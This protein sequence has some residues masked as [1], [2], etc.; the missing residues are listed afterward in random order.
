MKKQ[1][2]VAIIGFSYRLPGTAPRQFW[3]NLLA[4]RDLVTQVPQ[5]RWGQE[6]YFHPQKT[7]P[8]T[9]YTFAAGSIGDISGFDAEFFGISP[10]EAA[11]MDPQ[12]RLLLELSWE[13]LENSGIRAAEMRGSRC[14]VYIGISSVDY[15][16]RFAEDLA[17]AEPASATGTANSIAANRISYALDLHGPSMSIDTACSSS[18]IAFHLACQS[19]AAGES[20]QAITGGVSLHMHPYGFVTFSKASML[21][22]KGRCNVFDAAGDGYVRS[23]GAGIFVL[24]DHDQAVADGNRI[25][26]IVAG[27]ATNS[28][29]RKSGLTVPSIDAQA[30][31]LT[32]AYAEAGIAPSD[33]DYVEAH[34]TGTAVGDPVETHALGIALGQHR[35]RGNPLLIGS[36]K[37]NIGHLEAASGSAGLVKALYC[38]EHRAVPATI[39]LRDPNPSIR[40]DEWNLRVPT[41]TTPLREKGRLVLGINSFGF[42]GANAHVILESPPPQRQPAAPAGLLL[43]VL[44][45][46]KDADA[47][48][49]AAS[50]WAAFLR[51]PEN[52]S[53]LYEIAYSAAF[54]RDWHDHRAICLAHDKPSLAAALDTIASDAAAT[55]PLETGTLI[56]QPAMVAFVYSG[57][58]SQWDGMGRELLEKSPVFREAVKDVDACFRP[59]AGYSLIDELSGKNG[60]SRYVRTEI[61]QPA[62]FALQVGITSMLRNQGLEAAAVAGHSVGEVAAAWASGA[63][64]LEQATQVIYYRSQAQARTRGQGQMTAVGLG[65]A[66]IMEL[67]AD[68]D[69][70]KLI[71]IAGI[72]NAHSVTVAGAACSLDAMETALRER[73]VFHR[74]LELD[75]AFHSPAMDPI[76]PDIMTALCNL[77]PAATAIPFHSSV[78]GK[79]LDGTALDADY[80]W[81][82]IR[83]PVQFGK[84]IASL[85]EQ[86]TNIFIEIGPHAVLQG[87]VGQVLRDSSTQGCVIKTQMRDDGSVDRIWRSLCQAAIGGAS[88]DWQTWFPVRSR[89][90]QL[91]NYPWQREHYWHGTSP[92]SPRRLSRSRLHPLLGY[93]MND[94]DWVWEN[95]LDTQTCPSLADHVVGDTVVMPGTGYIEMA[96]AA[97]NAWRPETYIEIERLDIHAPLVFNPNQSKRLRLSIDVSDGSF[98]IRSR[99]ADSSDE[100]VRHA[101]GRLASE[102]SALRLRQTL[103]ALATRPPDFDSAH[104]DTLTRAAGLAY[105]PGYCAIEGIWLEGSAAYA[106]FRNPDAIAAELKK[107]HIHPALL[108]CTFQ[109]IIELLQDDPWLQHGTVYVPTCIEELI[110][111]SGAG[112]P[113][114]AQAVLLQRSPL[115][116]TASFTLFDASGN[117]IVWIREARFTSIRTNKCPRERLQLLDYRYS[118]FPHP[119]APPHVPRQL[120][121]RVLKKLSAAVRGDKTTPVVDRYAAEVEPLLDVLCSRFAIRA[122]QSL[123]QGSG[124]LTAARL[125]A[126][127][128]ATPSI[129]PLLNHLLV[130]LRDD[131]VIAAEG[132]DWRFLDSDDLPAAEDIWNGLIRDYPDYLPVIHSVGRVGMHLGDLLHGRRTPEQV[133]LRN[134]SLGNLNF[135]LLLDAGLARVQQH[136]AGAVAMTMKEIP[137]GARLRILEVCKDKPLF[138]A[139]IC[140]KIDFDRCG[141][142]VTTVSPIMVEDCQRLKENFPKINLLNNP[143][144]DPDHPVFPVNELYQLVIIDADLETERDALFALSYAKRL[145]AP[146]GVLVMIEQHP[147]RWMDMVFGT[148]PGWWSETPAG[149]WKSRHRTTGFWR[150]QASKAG[151]LASTTLDMT[152]EIGNGNYIL[153]AHAPESPARVEKT[154]ADVQR[155]WLLLAD[156]DPGEYSAKLANQLTQLLQARQDRVILATPAGQFGSTGNQHYQLDFSDP[157]Q[158]E[159]LLVHA[160]SQSGVIDGV[161]HLYGMADTDN[162]VPPLL[163][164][165]KQIDR[166]ASAALLI[167]ACEATGLHPT[168]WLLTSGVTGNRHHPMQ[169]HASTTKPSGM[170]AA[171]WGFGRTAMNETSAPAIRLV[172]I[173]AAAPLDNIAFTLAREFTDPDDE[174]EIAYTSDGERLAL[175]LRFTPSP[176]PSN[177][178]NE[179]SGPALTRLG[180]STQGQLRNLRWESLPA[181]P[182]ADDELEIEIRA[183]GLNFRDVMY[184]LGLLSEDAVEGG[185][186]GPTL[187]LEFAGVVVSTGP[188]VRGFPPGSRVLGF[189]ANSFSNRLRAKTSNIAL[190]PD[191]MSFEA[192]ATI[193]STFFTVHY[194]LNHLARLGQGEK[195][196][197][198]GAAGGIGIAAVQMARSCG[199]EIFATAGSPEKRDFLRLMG[200]KHVL[201]S[202]SLTYAEEI[203]AINGG[204]GVDVVLNSL[205]GEAINRNLRVLK[206]FGRFIELGKRDFQE[207][208]RIGLRQ[209]RNNISYFAVDADQLM[210][211]RPELTERLFRELMGMFAEGVL[212]PLPYQCFEA[213]EVID[214]FR[215]MQQSRHIGK[216]VVTYDNPIP[217][218][219]NRDPI[220]QKLSLPRDATYLITGGLGGFGLKT[221]E[222]LVE[223]GAGNLV[224]I[225]RSGKPAP[226]A[227]PVL[228][229]MRRNGVRVHTAACDVTDMA[230]LSKLFADTGVTLPPVRGIIHAAAVIEDGVIRNL[231]AGRIRRVLAPKILGAHYLHELTKN[232]NLDFFVMYS[233]A[234]TLFGNPG[235]AAYV[236]ANSYLEAYA[237]SLRAKGHRALCVRWGAIE[238]AGFLARNHDVL[239]ALNKRMGGAPLTSAVALD[240]LEDLLIAD[241]S[242]VG[243]LELDWNAL[244]RF[245]PAASS[246]KFGEIAAGSMENATNDNKQGHQDIHS[247][248]ATLPP[249][250]QVATLTAMLKRE[251]AEILRI[252]PDK[253]DDHRLLHDMGFDS[254]MG[255]ELA[256]AVESRF[257]VRL[258]VMALNDAPTAAKI[259]AII[260]DKLTSMGHGAESVS[261]SE[262]D[263]TEQGQQ[264]AALHGDRKYAEALARTADEMQKSKATLPKI[265]H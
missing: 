45:S 134:S 208:T 103:P 34:G 130:M 224:L 260:L 30:A 21:S 32:H 151:L 100:W 176:A 106:K 201:D 67:L 170:D 212:H 102:S 147:C 137:A 9:S 42:G 150:N 111:H 173:D 33:I 66:E 207:N 26:A 194:S 77:R 149:H 153:I 20:A 222:W 264:L 186:A 37:S 40:F 142:A 216:I 119:L 184:T 239:D 244:G 138:A 195:I 140:R 46:G 18:L 113:H 181:D 90:V 128:A 95:E 174:T 202:R 93:R 48:K 209:F 178:S 215:H 211:E 126:C 131:Q 62:L 75:Y 108:D 58:G 92:A 70:T 156:K 94:G 169:G 107:T 15:S 35:A 185:F 250:E 234:T 232:R 189:G 4:G 141:Y 17:A 240:T 22:Q 74:R 129:A 227:G 115:S 213:T 121:D 245:L 31:L 72:N 81:R 246:P 125:Q 24:K 263:I 159:S 98:A 80:W 55:L 139:A 89:L 10:R 49:Q 43:P 177:A 38:I 2:R 191:A 220:K 180:F 73:R 36:V 183:T 112:Q 228:D 59:L 237:A 200:V 97:A 120:F 88:I 29:G 133:L 78:S 157:A 16:F 109:L 50:Q 259:A 8:G 160:A 60:S 127:I 161:L 249:N 39:H 175:R 64:T 217:V 105:G 233:S 25:I 114:M 84:T 152:A 28:D 219:V 76:H 44:L 154:I 171:L 203:L 192:A 199:A 87:Y 65:E 251:I 117:A 205:A 3:P 54:H 63:L 262:T 162:D 179:N 47:L 230:A 238:D 158:F 247:L 118:A 61:A 223:K 136:L 218:A 143:P 144:R 256:T 51:D 146:G 148:R 214:A 165:K 27:T 79:T 235:Q 52:N 254:L 252:V 258:P 110:W 19:I 83:D 68:L 122:L 187:G 13:T 242:G 56:A 6:P 190:I 243:V 53:S 69:L 241:H 166:C 91:P 71:A 261:P 265:I 255:V 1:K 11:Q 182:C 41:A 210:K 168:C 236:A 96:L 204:T 116:L 196:L 145:L 7:H 123:A 248:L 163:Q 99:N 229:E 253:I 82:N 104:H 226:E 206:P 198:H 86:G 85:Q 167:K 23:E 101:S 12:Q 124:I 155:T 132:S 225:G 164:L 172:D 135:Q 188:L 197:I 193:P 14:G 5:N 257:A 57:N 221:A 231:D